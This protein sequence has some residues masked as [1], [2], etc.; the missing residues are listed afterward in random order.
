MAFIIKLYNKYDRWDRGHATYT[1]T[2]NE[3]PY[4]VMRV[5]MELGLPQVPSPLEYEEDLSTYHV[6]DTEE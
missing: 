6:Y 5:G 1:F 4:A 3:M 2:I